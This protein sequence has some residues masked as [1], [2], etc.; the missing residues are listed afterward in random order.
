[1]KTACEREHCAGAFAKLV[2]GDEVVIK[3][4]RPGIASK[5]ESDLSLLYWVARQL[6]DGL[7]EA[8]AFAPLAIVAEF[9]KSIVKE[10]NFKNELAH[11]QR[12]EANFRDW[13]HVHIPAVYPDLSSSSLMVMERLRGVKITDAEPWATCKIVWCVHDLQNGF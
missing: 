2:D 13:P 3:I 9:E 1:M 6:E 7:P 4:Q 11:L 12:F 5:I 10:L 8:R